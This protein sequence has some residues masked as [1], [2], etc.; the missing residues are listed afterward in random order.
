MFN[1]ELDKE[2]ESQKK[3]FY[4]LGLAAQNGQ[5]DLADK[6][7]KELIAQS[8]SVILRR[9]LLR[10]Y[11]DF[12]VNSEEYGRFVDLMVDIPYYLWPS[13]W[14]EP[15]C[16]GQKNMDHVKDVVEGLVTRKK[17]DSH[18]YGYVVACYE[19]GGRWDLARIFM[20]KIG[21]KS[22]YYTKETR[23]NYQGIKEM[24]LFRNIQPVFVQ[25]PLR[26]IQPLLSIFEGDT[27]RGRIMFVNNQ[28]VFEQAVREQSYN[29]LFLD[30]ALGDVGHPT[31]KGNY[32]LASHIARAIERFFINKTSH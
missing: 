30:R 12:L 6:L 10:K 2:P 18:V 31:D 28:D 22:S 23:K 25:Y 8:H 9:C 20:E 24:L 17:E 13:S 29:I 15:Y 7:F 1:A 5:R 26:S 3:I 16:H 32:I 14:V 19:K 4:F 27:D 21:A 11:G